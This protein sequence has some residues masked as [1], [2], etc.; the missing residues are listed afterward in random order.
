MQVA[1]TV[2]ADRGHAVVVGDI[3][4]MVGDDRRPNSTVLA[5]W[6]GLELACASSSPGPAVA[7]RGPPR[8]LMLTRVKGTAGATDRI[9]RVARDDADRGHPRSQERSL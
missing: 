6:V 9:A 4:E 5:D 8:G 1:V 3:A 7:G 2:L